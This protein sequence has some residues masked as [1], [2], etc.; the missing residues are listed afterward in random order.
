MTV[1]HR[2]RF[3]RISTTSVRIL[4]VIVLAS[5]VPASQLSAGEADTLF[6]EEFS[7]LDG[8]KPLTFPKIE[9]HS[10]YTIEVKGDERYLKT[11]SDK[12]AS[13]IIHS[14]QFDVYKFPRMTWRWKVENVYKKGDATK[15]SGDDYPLRVYIVFKY[16]PAEAG[17]WERR[18]Y[19]TAK[20]IYGAYPPHSSLNY[21]WANRR[22]DE[23]VITNTY[24]DQAKMIPLQQ[25]EANVGTW[26]V[27]NVN[28][29]E[30]YVKAFGKKPP[31]IASIAVMNDSD[32]TGEKAVSYVDYMKVYR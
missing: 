22:H 30:D 16:D 32:N 15:R 11:V 29:V 19:D 31:R 14:T 26:I 13:G 8:W 20:L 4:A 2:C 23:P 24:T 12:S 28:I 27:E 3:S 17:W 18:R 1:V 6:H 25:G 10:S 21:I 9:R 7:D 5:I